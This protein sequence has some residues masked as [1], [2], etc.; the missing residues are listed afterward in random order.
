MRKKN[1]TKK[2]THFN[3]ISL[4]GVLAKHV[5]GAYGTKIGKTTV[6]GYALA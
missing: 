4:S 5:N 2:K 6:H 1:G 3:A